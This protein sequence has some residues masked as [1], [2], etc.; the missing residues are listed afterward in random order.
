MGRFVPEAW[1]RFRDGV[2]ERDRSGDLADTYARLL[3][4]DDPSVR[5]QAAIDWCT[6]EDTHVAVLDDSLSPRP[7]VDVP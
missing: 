1:E 4:N 5:E 6:W 2:P 7:F 3:A